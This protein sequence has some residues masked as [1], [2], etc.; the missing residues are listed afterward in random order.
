MKITKDTSGKEGSVTVM[1]EREKKILENFA[2]LIPKLSEADKS[3]L[4]GLGEGMMIKIEM[5]KKEMMKTTA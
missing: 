1:E 2:V 5:P 4:L 3:Y